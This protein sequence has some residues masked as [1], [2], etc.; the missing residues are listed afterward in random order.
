MISTPSIITDNQRAK[1]KLNQKYLEQS[2]AES[3]L[4]VI[5]FFQR[6]SIPFSI[7]SVIF[8][9]FGFYFDLLDGFGM[10]GALI[11]GLFLG[12]FIEGGKH[13]SVKGAFSSF[14]FLWRVALSG[15][16]FL[17]LVGALAYHYKSMITFE[18]IS[19]RSTLES[20]VD[21]E[22]EIKNKQLDIIKATQA[23]NKELNPI[24]NNGSSLDDLEATKT[25]KSNNELAIAITKMGTSTENANALLRQTEKTAHQ[26]KNTLLFVF[27]T[28]E[29]M[30]LFGIIAKGLNASEVSDNVKS[31]VRTAEKLATY[32]ENVTTIIETNMI[33]N[34]MEKIEQKVQMQNHPIP[35]YEMTQ[36]QQNNQQIQPDKVQI[37]FN[38][39][40]GSN[41]YLMGV[42]NR[43]D[44]NSEKAPFLPIINKRKPKSSGTRTKTEDHLKENLNN[45]D[46]NFQKTTEKELKKVVDLLKFSHIEGEFIKLLWDNGEVKEGDKL[47]PK[48][49]VLEHSTKGRE[50]ERALVNLY[51][52]LEDMNL[53]MFKNGY[54][55]LADI[56]NVVKS[57]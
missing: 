15:L 46:D 20:K 51:A 37:A 31:I 56:E 38:A 28:I 39:N 18:N 35:P 48:R 32:E 57:N 50:T 4:S 2:G 13:Y 30:S 14:Y 29:F 44:E 27:I 45:S 11:L 34:S 3:K 19:V 53:I 25:I 16:A 1:Q 24:Y 33:N 6:S 17:F 55:A 5:N 23:N 21:K 8:S 22:I 10:I 47:I 12:L 43:L 54:R 42:T 7:F 52:K 49:F 26:N 41:G 36:N 9:A 40:S